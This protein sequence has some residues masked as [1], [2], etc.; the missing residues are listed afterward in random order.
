MIL[1]IDHLSLPSSDIMG[2][3]QALK[4]WGFELAFMESNLRNPKIKKQF[5]HKYEPT[6]DLSLFTAE[7]SLSVELLNHGNLHPAKTHIF[8]ILEN[9]PMDFIEIKDRREIAGIELFEAEI[10]TSHAAVYVRQNDALGG[11]R[12][13]KIVIETGDLGSSVS[14]WKKFG[15]KAQVQDQDFAILEFSS[16]FNKAGCQIILI[17]TSG[18][19][20]VF[21][22]NMGFNCLAL[23]TNSIE[24]EKAWL[25]SERIYTTDIEELVVNNKQLKIF[26]A[27]RNDGEIVEIIGLK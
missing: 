2:D 1:Q 21:L 14:F 23:I 24:K 9:P 22:D 10:K 5:M 26:F 8:P 18:Q 17:Y 4:S 6:H 19:K 11:F 20:E 25:D 27:K 16:V 7:G 15:F 3:K 13:N 12:F